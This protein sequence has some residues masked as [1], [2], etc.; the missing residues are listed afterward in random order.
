MLDFGKLNFS[1][2]FNP[3][4]AFPLDARSIFNSFE[5]AEAAA[6][7]A[8]EV[9]SSDGTYYFGELIVVVENNAAKLY[10]IQP[11][12]SLK[13]I[14]GQETSSNYN[15][16]S[17]LKLDRDTNTLSVDV[18]T[19]VLEDNTLPITSAAVYTE[20]GNINVLLQTI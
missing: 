7:N 12:K 20:V 15:I 5:E 4:S 6:K 1:V 9:G 14:S 10:V 19:E 2:S 13:E 11:D 3:T 8:V 18:A 16:G 17:G